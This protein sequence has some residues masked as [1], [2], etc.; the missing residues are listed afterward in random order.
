MNIQTPPMHT[1]NR[2]PGQLAIQAPTNNN[3]KI[4]PRFL[5]VYTPLPTTTPNEP[6]QSSV[7]SQDDR[8]AS[9][10][11]RKDVDYIQGQLRDGSS[12]L[13]SSIETIA[14]TPQK[15][16]DFLKSR[17]EKKKKFNLGMGN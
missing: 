14:S 10:F 4:E 5:E 17:K 16:L 2:V 6:R 8:Q 12:S 3:V 13:V 7:N 11:T 9:W 15:V 1:Y